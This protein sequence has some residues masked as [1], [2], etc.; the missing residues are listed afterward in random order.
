[1]AQGTEAWQ[2]SGWSLKPLLPDA[3]PETLEQAL[4]E[5]ESKTAAFE[6]IREEFKSEALTGARLDQM[7]ADY[8]ALLED[9]YRLSGYGSLW[10][11]SDTQ[12]KTPCSIATN[13]SR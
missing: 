6:S 9:A 11:A 1:M 10:F 2:L 5:L 13:C 4:G 7:L 3:K 12:S 8:E